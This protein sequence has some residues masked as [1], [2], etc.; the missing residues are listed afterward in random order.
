M[1][2][3]RSSRNNLQ[4][5]DGDIGPAVIEHLPTAVSPQCEWHTNKTQNEIT[6]NC[7]TYLWSITFDEASICTVCIN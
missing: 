1:L 4:Q 3:S 6:S 2:P 7:Y 5:D